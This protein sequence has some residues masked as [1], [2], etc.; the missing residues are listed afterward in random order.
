MG[1]LFCGTARRALAGVLAIG[2]GMPLVLVGVTMMGRVTYPPHL[3]SEDQGRLIVKFISPLLITHLITCMCVIPLV[4]KPNYLPAKICLLVC[5][6]L[7]GLLTFLIH[8]QKVE[9]GR[10]LCAHQCS[11]GVVNVTAIE[12]LDAGAAAFL[13]LKDQAF[14]AY[15]P[16]S[17]N[18]N[19]ENLVFP[20]HKENWGCFVHEPQLVRSYSSFGIWW[21]GTLM[22]LVMSVAVLRAFSYLDAP[23]PYTYSVYG[24]P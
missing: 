21:G 8:Q 20:Y 22:V 1:K 19:P 17:F 2:L 9:L 24:A 13:G 12:G 6:M 14:C 3:V 18:L 11:L 23:P 5:L 7:G 16:P 4:F 10:V 15:N